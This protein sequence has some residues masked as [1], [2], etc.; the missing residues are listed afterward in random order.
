MERMDG[1]KG[2]RKKEER[3]KEERKEERPTQGCHSSP[4]WGW[5]AYV[6]WLFDAGVSVRNVA[7]EGAAG[8][9]FTRGVAPGVKDAIICADKFEADTSGEGGK[10][11]A[12]IEH[13]FHSR[14]I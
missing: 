10:G 12:L 9:S 3:K 14:H 5:V 13:G 2:K 11:V 4:G 8:E 6:Y 7:W 1:R